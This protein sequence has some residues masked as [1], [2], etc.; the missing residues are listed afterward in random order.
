MAAPVFSL[1][2][3]WRETVVFSTCMTDINISPRS[4][5]PYASGMRLDANASKA[6]TVPVSSC[7]SRV[8]CQGSPLSTRYASILGA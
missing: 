4:F 5:L 8:S 7:I 3:S 6:Y 2:I 1:T